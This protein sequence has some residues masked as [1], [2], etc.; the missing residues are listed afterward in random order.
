MEP[1]RLIDLRILVAALGEVHHAGWWQSQFLSTIGMNY[2]AYPFPRT[3]FVAAIRSAWQSARLIHDQ[4]I[5]RGQ[6]MHLFRLD[7]Q[8]ER[9]LD[10]YLAEHALSLEQRLGQKLDDR[11]RLLTD[12]A[13][14]AGSSIV[15][16]AAGPVL[17]D[18]SGDWVP[19]W[20]AVYRNG[21]ISGQSVYPYATIE[22]TAMT[23]G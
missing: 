3:A 13:D 22:T 18:M 14:L 10:G 11:D 20:A 5:G 15:S 21:F 2:L 1:A 4:A 6:V 19:T 9:I 16:P 12:L 17:S 23:H 7:E 8:N